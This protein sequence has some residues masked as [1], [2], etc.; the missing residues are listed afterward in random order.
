MNETLTLKIRRFVISIIIFVII[1]FSGTVGYMMLEDWAFLDSLFFTII[2]L[3]TVG[4][5]IPADLSR[6]SHIFTMALILSGIT[7]VLYSLSTLTSFIVEGQMRNVLEV[8]K[9]MKKIDG[10]NNHYIVVG[11]GK[12]G[13]FVCQNL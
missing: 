4:Y 12:T 13:F 10:M 7:V 5:D 9:R 3:S 8:R 1:V 11:A 2:T 6:V